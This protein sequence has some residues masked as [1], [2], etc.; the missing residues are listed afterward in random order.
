MLEVGWPDPALVLARIESTR[1]WAAISATSSRM[2]SAE[3][4][5]VVAMVL[6]MPAYAWRVGDRAILLTL[7]GDAA[8]NYFNAR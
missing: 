1:S 2:I 8:P 6:R 7:L 3:I 4:V 5:V